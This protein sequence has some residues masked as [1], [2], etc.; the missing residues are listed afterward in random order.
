MAAAAGFLI[1]VGAM[2]G[3]MAFADGGA[4]S[5]YI[6]TDEDDAE[7]LELP[8][9]LSALEEELAAGA[10]VSEVT[11]SIYSLPCPG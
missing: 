11:S 1:A 4:Y 2:T 10:G 7:A 9:E 5:R 8:E 6:P 3:Q